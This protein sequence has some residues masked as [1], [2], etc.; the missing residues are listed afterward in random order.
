MTISIHDAGSVEAILDLEEEALNENGV[1]IIPTLV[2]EPW[3]IEHLYTLLCD[4]YQSRGPDHIYLDHEGRT[5][6]IER[7][8]F[9]CSV[10]ALGEYHRDCARKNHDGREFAVTYQ[11][12]TR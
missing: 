9:P 11:G 8:L 1:S 10:E 2:S 7:Q 3:A 5:M 12:A 6:R 4:R